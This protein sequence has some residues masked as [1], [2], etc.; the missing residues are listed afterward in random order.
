MEKTTIYTGVLLIVI[1]LSA[2]LI[3]GQPTAAIPAPFGIL[4]SLFGFIALKKENLKK[5]MIHAAVILAFLGVLATFTGVVNG[6][7]IIAGAEVARPL[8]ALVQT[9]MFVVC[10]GYVTAAVRSFIAARK[11]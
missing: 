2:S 6:L 7:R 1:G 8:A 10:A 9:L 5:H 11:K 4:I 3:T